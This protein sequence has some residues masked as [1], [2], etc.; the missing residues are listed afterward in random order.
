[1]HFFVSNHIFILIKKRKYL[2][3]V[4]VFNIEIV[5]FWITKDKVKNA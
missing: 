5:L 3:L 2:C 4:F 1:M